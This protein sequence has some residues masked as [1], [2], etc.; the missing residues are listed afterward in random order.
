MISAMSS[1]FARGS[2]MPDIGDTQLNA[3]S[4]VLGAARCVAAAV[5]W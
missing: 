2:N 4:A 3:L 1:S 5:C